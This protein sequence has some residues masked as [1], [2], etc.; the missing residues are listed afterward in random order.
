MTQIVAMTS[1]KIVAVRDVS[2]RLTRSA[3]VPSRL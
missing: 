2:R 3:F 1:A